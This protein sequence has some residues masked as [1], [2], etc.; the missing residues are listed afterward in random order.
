MKEFRSDSQTR[1]KAPAINSNVFV[2][3][4]SPLGIPA[5]IGKLRETANDWIKAIPNVKYIR[6]R[7]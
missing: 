1:K 6:L 4:A 3:I 2:T 5:S 7:S